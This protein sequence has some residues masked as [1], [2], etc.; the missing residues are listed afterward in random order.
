MV[1]ACVCVGVFGI[2]FAAFFSGMSASFSLVG[3]S[4]ETLRAAQIMSEKLDTLRLYSWDQLTTPGYIPTTFQTAFYPTNGLNAGTSPSQ[5]VT[6]TG[7]ITISNAP[8]VSE[9]Y[10]NEVRT[11]VIDLTWQ[12]GAVTHHAEMSTMFSKY[13][14]QTYSLF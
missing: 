12:R 10:S 6:Y 11:V 9:D 14:M 2:I 5:G 8:I 1:E 3:S 13:G 7:T 4:R